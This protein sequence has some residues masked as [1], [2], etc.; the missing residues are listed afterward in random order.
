MTTYLEKLKIFIK[1]NQID[2]EPIPYT[3]V[4]EKNE[5]YEL[6]YETYKEIPTACPKCSGH[7]FWQRLE[8]DFACSIC[9]P[10]LQDLIL[11][12]QNNAK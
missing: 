11:G 3:K 4:N 12:V 7:D 1:K 5:F 8:G 6:G 9:L 2:I 10:P